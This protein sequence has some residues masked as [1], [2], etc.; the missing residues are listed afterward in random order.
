[1][2]IIATYLLLFPILVSAQL[3]DKL[4]LNEWIFQ[5]EKPLELIDLRSINSN[6]IES[7][8]T[9]LN[10][11]KINC[12]ENE[13]GSKIAAIESY[14]SVNYFF[15]NHEIEK[16]SVPPNDSLYAEQY[17]LGLV[18]LENVWLETTGGNMDNGEEVVIAVL[19]DGF[20]T[21]NEDYAQN[22]WI[23]LAEIPDNNIDDDN[24]GYIDDVMGVNISNGSNVHF[25]VDHGTEVLGI[26]GAEGDNLIGIAGVTWNTKLMIISGVSNVGEIIKG[27]DYTYRM[28]KLYIDS[29]GSEGANIVVNN[30][31][32][33]LSKFFP[34]DFP[35]W[36]EM[37]DLLGTV[38]ILSVGATANEDFD[39]ES[40]GD[41][42]TLCGSEYLIVVSNSNS[43]DQK[44][45]D[46]ADSNVHVDLFAPGENIKCTT[47]GSKYTSE[48]GTSFSSPHVTGG[49]ALLYTVDCAEFTTL[50]ENDKVATARLIRDVIYSGVDK[51]PSLV[52]SVTGGRLNIYNSLL[53]LASN[54]CN[55]E[56]VSDLSIGLVSPSFVRPSDGIINVEYKTPIF[57]K[58]IVS[59]Y[60]MMGRLIYTQDIFPSIFSVKEFDINITPFGLMAGTYIIS[61]ENDESIVSSKI[62]IT[63]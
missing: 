58:H 50:Y 13:I 32:G 45:E 53:D 23:N 35:S 46:A 1:M 11:Y 54:L 21:A 33:G 2:K 42:P 44:V 52:N 25:V 37:Y 63:N 51:S 12:T 17:N 36:C 22:L 55:A 14:T 7:L 10:I 6:E 28:R 62:V 56:T 19:D 38:G 49:I 34:S 60:D 39:V 48:N 18:G 40:E 4:V 26:L 47:L 57:S 27:F 16:R 3:S 31:S 20:D 43:I 9:A 59:L 8:C 15:R 5:T 61:I 24:N 30:F 29:N 41:M